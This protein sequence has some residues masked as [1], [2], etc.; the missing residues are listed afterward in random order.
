MSAIAHFLSEDVGRIDFPGHMLNLESFF[1]DPLADRVL[2]EF[3]V[4]RHFGGH[5]I[6]PPDPCIIVVVEDCGSIERGKSV[7]CIGDTAGEISEVDNLL[8]SSVGCANLGLART[9]GGT[10][11]TVAKPTD[12]APPVLEN[13]PTIHAA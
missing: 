10:F 3:N 7:S 2:T 8:R 12:W 1:L 5:F 13:D 6:G 9:Q 4:L 11:L